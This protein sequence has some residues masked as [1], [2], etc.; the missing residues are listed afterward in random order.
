MKSF[1]LEMVEI[2]DA[3]IVA[4][5]SGEGQVRFE[6]VQKVEADFYTDLRN[7]LY[8]LMTDVGTEPDLAAANAL[9]FDISVLLVRE[10]VLPKMDHMQAVVLVSLVGGYRGELIQQLAVRFGVS[11]LISQADDDDGG[12]QDELPT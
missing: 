4:S 3:P 7:K 5:V 8:K 12:L 9:M 11:D 6:V 1:A 2:P 10:C